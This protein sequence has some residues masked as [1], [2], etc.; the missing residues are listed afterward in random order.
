MDDDR[1]FLTEDQ[2]VELMALFLGC[3]LL[4]RA[5]ALYGP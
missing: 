5:P 4:L 3:S 2:A 1:K